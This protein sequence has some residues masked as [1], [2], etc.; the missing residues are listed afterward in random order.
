MI[1]L[2]QIKTKFFSGQKKFKK[3]GLVT[4]PDFFWNILLS[5]FLLLVI[6][7]LIFGFFLF[8]KINKE[9]FLDDSGSYRKVDTVNKERLDK[10]LDYFSKRK[11]KSSE[12]LNSPV[13]FI[14]PYL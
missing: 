14:D 9:T 3:G 11:N 6:V 12:I 13:P 4:N 7:A 5:L 2:N 10:A 8:K 1:S